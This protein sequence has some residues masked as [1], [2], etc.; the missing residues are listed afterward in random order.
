MSDTIARVHPNRLKGLEIGWATASLRR[1][2]G[3]QLKCPV[4]GNVFKRRG[5]RKLSG[6]NPPCCS[7]DCKAKSQSL[8]AVG[9]IH[10]RRPKEGIKRNCKQCGQEFQKP[11]SQ[12]SLYCSAQCRFSDPSVFDAISGSRHYNWKGGITR[13]NQTLRKSRIARK[14]RNVVLARDNHTCLMC[15]FK[16]SKYMRAH[17]VL[18]WS[19]YPQFRF[20]IGNGMTLCFWC[21]GHIHGRN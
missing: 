1:N 7:K 11:K 16:G 20:F 6:K 5:N 21:H 18:S 14:W 2:P 13:G 17:H 15:G 19:E 12:D 3:N 9:F 4:C 8:S 10:G